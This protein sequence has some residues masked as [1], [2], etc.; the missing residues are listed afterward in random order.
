VLVLIPTM[1]AIWLPVIQ[2]IEKSLAQ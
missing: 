2:F 1:I